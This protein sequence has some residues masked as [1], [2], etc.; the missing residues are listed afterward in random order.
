MTSDHMQA[1][2]ALKV[3]VRR[4][5]GLETAPPELRAAVQELFR[6][7]R[8]PATD[9][10][11]GFALSRSERRQ[12]DLAAAAIALAGGVGM[13]L[14]S[15]PDDCPARPMATMAGIPPLGSELGRQLV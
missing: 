8:R 9:D 15:S 10:G 6:T 2:E 1:D 3:A 7:G 12:R 11:R 13:D 14:T 4:T 5:W